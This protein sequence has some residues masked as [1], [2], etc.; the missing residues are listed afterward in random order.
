[1][2]IAN[3]TADTTTIQFENN[4]LFEHVNELENVSSVFVYGREVDDFHVMN[5]NAIFVVATAAIQELDRQV[6]NLTTEN[7]TLKTQLESLEARVVAL[8]A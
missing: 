3:I 6:Q 7:A 4:G 2:S 5:K 8:E 1:M